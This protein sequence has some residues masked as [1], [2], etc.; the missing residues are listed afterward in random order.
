MS[1]TGVKEKQKGSKPQASGH[2]PGCLATG[3]G[4]EGVQCEPWGWG[5]IPSWASSL[6]AGMPSWPFA[7]RDQVHPDQMSFLSRGVFFVSLV[8]LGAGSGQL[9]VQPRGCGFHRGSDSFLRSN[10]AEEERRFSRTIFLFQ[11][12]L[13]RQAARLGLTTEAEATLLVIFL[14]PCVCGSPEQ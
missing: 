14:G 3:G 7:L 2:S 4:R 11:V 12:P 5:S 1:K 13:L 8:A 6:A 9:E 10:L